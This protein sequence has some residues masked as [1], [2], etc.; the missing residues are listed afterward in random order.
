ML[1][2][3]AVLTAVI[4]LLAIFTPPEVPFTRLLPAAPA[5]AAS[6]WSVA[7]TLGLGVICALGV[8]AYSMFADHDSTLYTAGAIGAVTLAAAY[9]SHLRLQRE[10][11]LAEVRA[12]ADTTQRVLLRP[13]PA[14]IGCVRI[15]TLY[16]AAAPQARVGGDFYAVADTA[17]GLRLII[18]DVRGK[19]L[20]AV[21]VASAVLGS[22]REAAYDAPD[23]GVLARRLDT[24]VGRYEAAGPGPDASELF[25]TAVL[26]EIPTHGSHARILSCGHPPVLLTH[27]GHIRSLTPR[28]SSPPINLATLLGGAY[29]AEEVPFVPGD[30]LLLYTDGV[31][32]TRDGDGAFFPLAAWAGERT[33]VPPRPL[34]DQLHRALLQHSA[35][36]LDDDIAVL[37]VRRT[38]SE[39]AGAA[40]KG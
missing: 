17:H 33:S 1:W 34:L 2:T 35:G 20:D 38:S 39:A 16:V 5:L 7:A 9:A 29:H 18:G 22:F 36:G 31:T 14:R 40:P 32:E 27:D 11:T 12:V 28:T 8:I 13:V 15:E 19:G 6:L 24:T 10:D 25:A 21:G 26:A 4:A 23:L 30:Q 37:A 3:P